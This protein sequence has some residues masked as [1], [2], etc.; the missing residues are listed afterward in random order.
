MRRLAPIL[1][2]LVL[3]A[4]T[5]AV[6]PAD[7]GR[8][9]RDMI[10]WED[11]YWYD[12]PLSVTVRDGLSAEEREAITARAMARIEY[13]RGLE[14]RE[15]VDV[16]VI[17]R[18]EYL[19]HRGGGD[20][21]ETHALWNDQVWEA[22][23][24]VG[25]DRNVSDVLEGTLGSSIVGYYASGTGDIVIV[26]DGEQAVLSRGTL[27]HELVHALQDQHFGLT[28]DGR[29]QDAQLARNGVIEG[30][31]NRIQQQYQSR[32]NRVWSCV[33]TS[34]APTTS[35]SQSDDGSGDSADGDNGSSDG[36]STAAY[37][38]GVFLVIYQPYAVGPDFVDAIAER[39]GTAA[40]NGLYEDL[41]AS[42]EQVLHPSAYPDEEPVNVSVP[43][44]SNADW[45]RFDTEP[46]ADT[47]GEASI[48]A[49]VV[50]NDMGEPPSGRY[51]YDHPL[52]QGWG[53]DSVVPYRDGGRYGY[54][55]EIAWDTEADARE[56]HEAYL[57]LLDDH[58]AE[59]LGDRRYRVPA[60]DAFSG[61]Y[62]VVREGKRIRIVHGPTT[63]SLGDIHA[64]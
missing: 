3:A 47:V 60:D 30:E 22:I 10:G 63:A 19:A 5:G 6:V 12:D 55:W 38:R 13:L 21:D 64:P 25:E 24:L 50:S 58:D 20:T 26:S 45:R 15:S 40:V 34:R 59:Q 61:G 53:G 39:G 54:V 44:R 27:V 33:D 4:T 56:F 36:E 11:G 48:Y 23:F 18:A 52:S 37:D 28:G 1:L 46:V 41:P 9:S 49:M 57:A 17:S 31:A 35:S 42:T 16:R 51:S 43:D 62:R 14:F 29:T 32:C 7:D 8:L 2:L